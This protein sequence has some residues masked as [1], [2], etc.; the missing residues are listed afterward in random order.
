[1]K[2]RL[3]QAAVVAGALA[4]LMAG[5][6]PLAS[7]SLSEQVHSVRLLK[8]PGDALRFRWSARVGEPGHFVLERPDGSEV[9]TVATVGRI[10]YEAAPPALSGEYELRYRDASGR[11]RVLAHVLVACVSLDRDTPATA[12]GLTVPPEAETNVPLR[13]SMLISP[14]TVGC[15]L[16][17]GPASA[18]RPP[19]TP[20]PRS[21]A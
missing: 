16:C 4:P 2:V 1:M 6:D 15:A 9:W 8:A 21:H 11:Q 18:V 12:M 19:P 14:E 7:K 13:V 5:A 17:L 3:L 20:P 10:A